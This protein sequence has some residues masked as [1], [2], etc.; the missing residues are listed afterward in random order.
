[1]EKKHAQLFTEMRKELSDAEKKVEIS[2]PGNEMLFYM[3]ETAKKHGWE[4]QKS[5]GVEFDG[6][7]NIIEILESAIKAE[8][9]AVFLY[10]SFR[11]F[12]PKGTAKDKMSEIIREETLH[13]GLLM[14]QLR[15]LN[16]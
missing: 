5:P 4:G 12:V 7:E 3:E 15:H 6:S 14:K 10:T 16:K 9:E 8:K 11:D 1:M 2:D 13:A